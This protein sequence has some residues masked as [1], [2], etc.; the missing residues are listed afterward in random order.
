M[1]NGT[2]PH[3]SVNYVPGTFS[4]RVPFST[5]HQVP[6][7]YQSNQPQAQNSQHRNNSFAEK[8][9]NMTTQAD[10]AALVEQLQQLLNIHKRQAHQVNEVQVVTPQP[11][12]TWDLK[13]TAELPPTQ[14][15]ESE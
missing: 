3:A 5:H 11:R 15:E 14:E 9:N 13:T 6:Y 7:R 8:Q 4:M 2:T 10:T 1:F 12:T